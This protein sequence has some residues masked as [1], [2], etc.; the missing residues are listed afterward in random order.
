MSKFKRK[1]EEYF[2]QLGH[3]LFRNRF[4]TLFL[5]FLFIGVLVYNIPDIII[6]TSSEAML[7]EDDPSRIEYNAFRDQFGGANMIIVGVKAPN[8]FCNDFLKKLKAL[9]HELEKELP[10][11]QE[12]NSLINARNTRGEN[13][14]L[15]V[16]DL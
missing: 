13:D 15:Y 11:V 3:L 10:Y 2:E 8:I 16:D 6:D 4:K 14:V 1:I 5:V 12:V 9:H 7:H